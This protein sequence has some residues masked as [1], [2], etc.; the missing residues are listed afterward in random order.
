M[1]I[2]AE[3]TIIREVDYIA[4]AIALLCHIGK[5]K[6]YKKIQQELE[7]KYMMTFHEDQ[8]KFDILGSIEEEAGKVLRK[9]QEEMQY[10]FSASDEEKSDCVGRLL[11]AWDEW[12]NEHFN[13]MKEFRAYLAGMD[14]KAFC[15]NFGERLQGYDDS[16]RDD[17]SFDVF[18]TP[19]EIIQYIMK[20][21]APESDKWKIQTVLL[22]RKMHQ[23]KVLELV[24][25]AVEVIHS[26]DDK[27]TILVENFYF[28]W[29]NELKE[30]TFREFV[31]EKISLKMDE[32]PFGYELRPSIFACNI[33]G[34]HVNAND[35]GTYKEKDKGTLGILF[36]DEFDVRTKVEGNEKF[37]HNFAL[38]VLKQLSDSSKFEILSYTK[39]KAAY[40][41]ELAKHL[42]LTTA[43]IS[44]HMTSLVATGLVDMQKE[45]NRVYYRTNKKVLEE[46]LDYCKKQLT[47]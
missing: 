5:G 35:D 21:D 34:I 36:G 8:V 3:K 23:E 1:K 25:I 30:K 28:Y 18:S 19:M 45:E 20:M 32:N 7:K 39:D 17:S 44:H 40:G 31:V 4:E 42:N 46:V 47:E 43:T 27:L 26:F 13:D 2:K 29:S 6:S 10:Y 15:E 14:E 12:N 41:N 37:F 16:I 22:E 33:M 11:L 24:Q 38:Q 9:K